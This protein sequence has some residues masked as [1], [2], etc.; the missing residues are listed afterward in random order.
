MGFNYT[1]W[2]LIGVIAGILICAS[3][4]DCQAAEPRWYNYGS[5]QW[6]TSDT[7]LETGWQ[8]INVVDYGQTLDIPNHPNQHE[9]NKHIDPTNKDATTGYFILMGLGH[10]YVSRKLSG[11]ART[12]WQGGTVLY[13]LDNALDNHELKLRVQF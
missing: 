8:V 5:H 12:A 3:V 13:S 4:R 11:G 2:F 7:V 10:A 6:S 9:T 1:I